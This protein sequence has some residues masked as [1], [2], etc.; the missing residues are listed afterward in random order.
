MELADAPDPP[1]LLPLLIVGAG[2]HSLALV[3]KLL[4][5]HVDLWEGKRPSQP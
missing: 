2:P 1:G 3:T 5:P 4:E